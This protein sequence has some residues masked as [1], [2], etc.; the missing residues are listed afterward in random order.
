MAPMQPL[1]V[2]TP[3]VVATGLIRVMI[4]DDSAVIRGV[5]GRVLESDPDI[6]IVASVSDGRQATETVKRKAVDVVLLD[7]EMPVMD[8]LTALPRI[9]AARP[10][11]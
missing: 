4:V 2:R 5:F 3:G 1:P 11:I 7:I 9:I 8:G 6:D 10:G